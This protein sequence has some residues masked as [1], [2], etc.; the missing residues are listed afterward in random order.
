[1]A[2]PNAPTI[3]TQDELNAII[4]NLKQGTTPYQLKED[5]FGNIVITEGGNIQEQKETVYTVEKPIE[6]SDKFT[7]YKQSLTG[8]LIDLY[9]EKE[10]QSLIARGT[11]EDQIDE[12]KLRQKATQTVSKN[13]VTGGVTPL[14]VLPPFETGTSVYS[15]VTP[16]LDIRGVAPPVQYTPSES[17]GVSPLQASLYAFSRQQVVTPTI[18]QAEREAMEVNRN[19]LFKA[20]K[21]SYLDLNLDVPESEIDRYADEEIAAQMA[22]TYE[23]MRQDPS[24]S[25]V[26]AYQLAMIELNQMENAPVIDPNALVPESL[27]PQ[28][29]PMDPMVQAFKR[30]VDAGKSF[31]VLTPTQAAYRRKQLQNEENYLTKKYITELQNQQVDMIEYSPT[32][33]WKPGQLSATQTAKLPATQQIPVELWTAIINNNLLANPPI[34]SKNFDQNVKDYAASIDTNLA[35]TNLWK[36]ATGTKIFQGTPSQ[37]DLRSLAKV[38]AKQTIGDYESWIYDP[39]KVDEVLADPEKF[40]EAGILHDLGPLGGQAETVTGWAMR[41]MLVPA[42]LMVGGYLHYVN[43]PLMTGTAQLFGRDVYDIAAERQQYRAKSQALYQDSPVLANVALNKGLTGEAEEISKQIGLDGWLKMTHQAGSFVGDFIEPSFGIGTATI[44]AYK[45]VKGLNQAR[46]ISLALLDPTQ[47]VKQS[48][49]AWEAA[50]QGA[51]HGFYQDSNIITGLRPGTAAKYRSMTAPGDIRMQV[52]NQFADEVVADTIIND[53][54]VQSRKQAQTQ[55]E[56]AKTQEHSTVRMGDDSV[57]FEQLSPARQQEIIDG[58]VENTERE[59]VQDALATAKL[60]NTGAAAHYQQTGK[61]RGLP[62]KGQVIDSLLENKVLKNSADVAEF[63]KTWDD[64]MA[65]RQFVQDG[66]MRVGVDTE[67][68]Q[69]LRQYYGIGDMAGQLEA[70]A[71][72]LPHVDEAFA[73][74]LVMQIVPEMKNLEKMRAITKRTFAHE[75][76]VPEIINRASKTPLGETLYSIVK[77]GQIVQEVVPEIKGAMYEARVQALQE[78]YLTKP[79]EVGTYYKITDEERNA[80][81]QWLE[82]EQTRPD[83]KYSIIQQRIYDTVSRGFLSVED[84]RFLIDSNLDAAASTVQRDIVSADA[85]GKLSSREQQRWMEAGGFRTYNNALTNFTNFIQRKGRQALSIF[86]GV[87]GGVIPQASGATLQQRRLIKETAQEASTMDL[88]LKREV[89]AL[90]GSEEV[91]ARYVADPEQPVDSAQAVGMAIVGPKPVRDIAVLG[92]VE[93]QVNVPAVRAVTPTQP[94]ELLQTQR[95]VEVVGQEVGVYMPAPTQTRQYISADDATK[96]LEERFFDQMELNKRYE[97]Q[98]NELKESAPQERQRIK[99][100]TK[101]RRAILKQ[102]IKT[103]TEKVNSSIDSAIRE[104]RAVMDKAKKDIIGKSES[105]VASINSAANI[106]LKSIA[107][108]RKRTAQHLSDKFKEAQA[109]IEKEADDLVKQ[110]NKEIADTIAEYEKRYKAEQE[111]IKT[112]LDNALEKAESDYDATVAKLDEIYN[113]AERRLQEKVEP[114]QILNEMDNAIEEIKQGLTSYADQQALADFQ[115]RSRRGYLG[116][117]TRRTSEKIS[118]LRKELKTKKSEIVAKKK[119]AIKK[120]F[121]SRKELTD[122]LWNKQIQDTKATRNITIERIKADKKAAID[123]LKD[124]WQKTIDVYKDIKNARRIEI[125]DIYKESTAQIDLEKTQDMQRIEQALNAP[126]PVSK[127]GYSFEELIENSLSTKGDAMLRLKNTATWAVDRLFF[128]VGE[129]PDLNSSLLRAG[130]SNLTYKSDILSAKGKALLELAV[131]KFAVAT[132][133]DPKMF[134]ENFNTLVGEASKILEQPSNIRGG[135]AKSIAMVDMAKAQ[136]IQ[137]EFMA[138][139]YFYAEGDRIVARNAIRAVEQELV[140]LAPRVS[141]TY[142][143]ETVKNTTVRSYVGNA[144]NQGTQAKGKWWNDTYV[145]MVGDEELKAQV[146]NNTRG[147]I[148]EK[149]KD[150]WWKN[151]VATLLNDAQ[152]Y[153]DT[154]MRKNGIDVQLTDLADVQA[155]LDDLFGPRNQKLGKAYLGEKVYNEMNKALTDARLSGL[156]QKINKYL[157][158]EAKSSPTWKYT[159]KALDMLSNAL[160]GGYRYTALLGSR[161]YFHTGNVLTGP[162]MAYATTGNFGTGISRALAPVGQFSSKLYDLMLGNLKQGKL[163]QW[164]EVKVMTGQ[165]LGQLTQP[166]GNSIKT[167]FADNAGSKY[168]NEIAIIDPVGRPY[169]HGEIYEL[170]QSSGIRSEVNFVTSAVDNGQL[171]N[172]LKARG[173]NASVARKYSQKIGEIFV[174]DLTIKE[175]MVFRLNVFYDAVAKG[176]AVDEAVQLAKRSMYDYSD[177]SAAEK[178]IATQYL[179]FYTFSRQNSSMFIRAFT[180]LEVFKRYVNT[181]KAQRGIESVL[182]SMDEESGNREVYEKLNLNPMAME[183]ITIRMSQGETRDYYM[184]SPPIPTLGAMIQVFGLAEDIVSVT[185]G[186][187]PTAITRTLSGFVTPGMKIVLQYP[188]MF[189]YRGANVPYEYVMAA[190]AMCA[191]D[192]SCTAGILQTILGGEIQPLPARPDEGGVGG[193]VYPMTEAQRERLVWGKKMMAVTG[194]DAPIMEWSKIFLGE[195]TGKTAQQTTTERVL[196]LTRPMQARTGTKLERSLLD[197]KQKAM[198]AELK[199]VQSQLRKVEETKARQEEEE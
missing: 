196:G 194:F 181:L 149:D 26:E 36:V 23:M 42:N 25:E 3:V 199:S 37:D 173:V 80:I 110:E 83:P 59:V 84:L 51:V 33:F 195:E 109:R 4:A 178:T 175:D 74:N 12:D 160:V 48:K 125:K 41:S 164:D 93:K 157:R 147:T 30:Q 185:R 92:D 29:G 107:E 172:F 72:I 73:R 69:K 154:V 177:M 52:T 127:A 81:G 156:T 117:D 95:N 76:R 39:N 22:A 191:D 113:T 129:K 77:R 103:L 7:N 159:S 182:R 31:K 34:I 122:N 6:P 171:V 32:R 67:L 189:E 137:F 135:N 89:N 8:Q 133:A 120:D 10:R 64:W 35:P 94:S 142:F 187:E 78:K 56:A 198:E 197:A 101:E 146:W 183:K 27:A 151:E 99:D 21:Q 143:D 9:V 44:G 105:E 165:T 50:K 96:G 71:K 38:R 190:N 1:M 54:I 97:Q 16:P 128:T 111:S 161:I 14:L 112:E 150:A 168:Y 65:T 155:V 61:P 53:A 86:T 58:I 116:W 170:I 70:K 15:K 148:L 100:R 85:I 186:E 91:R 46:Q 118:D 167:I 166:R 144:L 102:E 68:V 162:S 106:E 114:R 169:T 104:E 126:A 55:V 17:G 174:Q 136:E 152:K 13:Y 79:S 75:D 66:L 139:M 19:E 2:L 184:M 153:G 28:G 131:N 87:D 188:D 192:P 163:P 18:A 132:Y 123:Q 108:K 134:W 98:M 82:R 88:K 138:G 62:D 63:E 20:V 60:D 24:L 140:D 158:E 11:P 145:A 124:T 115:A 141:N 119:D 121:A 90:M 43:D 130:G 49:T 180:D 5:A 47:T 176:F 179:M 45:S 193:Y 57:P 40:V